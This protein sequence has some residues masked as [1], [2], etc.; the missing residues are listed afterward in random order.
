MGWYHVFVERNALNWIKWFGNKSSS[1]SVFRYINIYILL[2]NSMNTTVRR[3]ILEDVFFSGLSSEQ[4]VCKSVCENRFPFWSWQSHA[5]L[6]YT[7][8]SSHHKRKLQLSILHSRIIYC[9]YVCINPAEKSIRYKSM[10]I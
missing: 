2:F 6:F 5:L 1:K 10:H 3:H 4:C 8:R 9:N 7:S